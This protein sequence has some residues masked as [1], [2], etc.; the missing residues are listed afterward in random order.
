M[1]NTTEDIQTAAQAALEGLEIAK[2]IGLDRLLNIERQ[3]KWCSYYMY[4]VKLKEIGENPSDPRLMFEQTKVEQCGD[5]PTS[6]CTTYADFVSIYKPQFYFLFLK[7]SGDDYLLNVLNVDQ[8]EEIISNLLKS[9]ENSHE[10]DCIMAGL[11]YFGKIEYFKELLENHNM[12]KNFMTKIDQ[13]E[14]PNAPEYVNMIENRTLLSKTLGI[15][16]TYFQIL[17]GYY[18]NQKSYVPTTLIEQYREYNA[19]YETQLAD[20]MK[21]LEKTPSLQLCWA[22]AENKN[23]TIANNEQTAAGINTTA[24]VNCMSDAVVDG[25]LNGS[26]LQEVT[27]AQIRLSIQNVENR[28]KEQIAELETKLMTEQQNSYKKNIIIT[29]VISICIIILVFFITMLLNI[30]IKGLKS[31]INGGIIN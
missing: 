31:K 21:I 25:F 11:N 22:S 5:I 10:I 6:I 28:N 15:E 24:V 30:K 26:E 8:C 4:D 23:I 14:D 3:I 20:M 13:Y 12:N 16:H 17:G 19:K 27:V 9:N 18:F 2:S 1:T 29:V 7:P